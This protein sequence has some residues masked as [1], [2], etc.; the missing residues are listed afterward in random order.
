[1]CLA[2]LTAGFLSMINSILGLRQ[3]TESEMDQA[4]LDYGQFQPDPDQDNSVW[5]ILLN[6]GTFTYR[7]SD[8]DVR[9]SC[10][11][12]DMVGVSCIYAG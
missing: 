8:W 2:Q 6:D 9:T 11:T 7:C 12:P 1:M 3:L 4:V 5:A 10:L